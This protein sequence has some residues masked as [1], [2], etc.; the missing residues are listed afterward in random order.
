MHGALGQWT[1][2]SYRPSIVLFIS[3]FYL[4][5][6]RV[7]NVLS[8]VHVPKEQKFWKKITSIAMGKIPFR[9][10]F[11]RS[12]LF[13]FYLTFVKISR[14]EWPGKQYDCDRMGSISRF[15]LTYFNLTLANSKF[16]VNCQGH[17][18]FDCEYNILY[19]KMQMVSVQCYY[20][21]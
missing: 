21:A 8:F 17:A 12:S 9:P 14:N 7:R 18:H 5:N 1:L 16:K 11:S 20:W 19:N 13:A 10:S 15:R 3:F 2:V 6:C 4:W